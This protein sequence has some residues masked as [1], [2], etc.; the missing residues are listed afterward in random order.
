MECSYESAV[1]ALGT[2]VILL[3][4]AE[5]TLQ[6]LVEEQ[7]KD[8]YHNPKA[9]DQVVCDDASHWRS[10]DELESIMWSWYAMIGRSNTLGI[11]TGVFSALAGIYALVN[12]L[13][14][15]TWTWAFVSCV[16]SIA[17][18]LFGTGTLIYVFVVEYTASQISFAN[19]GVS[20][21]SWKLAG[22]AI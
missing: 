8:I 19:F 5:S 21:Q 20:S 2:L 22:F 14:R 3:G 17:A 12:I 11:I 10:C 16:G 15:R 13:L 9:W 1:A 4:V 6:S 7:V 18:F